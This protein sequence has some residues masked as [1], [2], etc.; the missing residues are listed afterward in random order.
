MCYFLFVYFKS[1]AWEMK[2]IK[3]LPSF[4]DVMSPLTF[5]RAQPPTQHG[6][7]DSSGKRRRWRRRLS[8]SCRSCSY[9]RKA[10]WLRWRRLLGSVT[11]QRQNTWRQSTARR[12]RSWGLSI[13]SR[14]EKGLVG[15]N[16]GV[17][18]WLWENPW[19]KIFAVCVRWR[20]WRS[21]I[22]PLFRSS[23][24]CITSPWQRCTRS[25]P[26]PWEAWIK[27][28]AFVT[29]AAGKRFNL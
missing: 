21:T 29:A 19:L 18:C 7:T 25:T 22:G 9:S 2:S 11:P 8:G 5:L 13:R 4:T 20:R 26:A 27:T 12:W 3:L 6:G 15:R 17:F 23:E 14:W 10:S 24:T 16:T 1:C 28:A